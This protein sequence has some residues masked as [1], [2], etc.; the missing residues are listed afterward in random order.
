MQIAE[1][2]VRNGMSAGTAFMD[3]LTDLIQTKKLTRIIETGTFQ[4]LGTTR[5]ILKGLGKKKYTFVSIEG[6]P[7][8]HAQA[9]KNNPDTRVDF[10]LGISIP[11]ELRPKRDEIKFDGYDA[12][13][14]VDHPERTRARLYF[15]EIDYDVPDRM[16]DQAMLLT[17]H[18]PQLV[19]LDSAGHVGLIEFQ[20]FMTMAK[21]EFYLALDDTNHVKHKNTVK[22]IEA[23]DRFTLTFSTEEKFGS[24]IYHVQINRSDERVSESDGH[25]DHSDDA[26]NG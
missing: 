24:R 2:I 3:A 14:I 20:Y 1:H 5:A 11:K 15:N 19:V 18:Y 22:L 12:D 6:N 4:G 17:A 16:L 25:E 9:V 8:N 23:D 13:V 26:D 21:G 10:L 7:D